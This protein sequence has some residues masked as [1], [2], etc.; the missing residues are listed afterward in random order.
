MF[1]KATVISALAGL[2]VAAPYHPT[3]VH[4]P[5]IFVANINHSGSPIQFSAV[6]AKGLEFNVNNG[7]KTYCPAGQVDCSHAGTATVFAYQPE[8]QTLAMDVTVPGGQRAF[9]RKDGSLGFTI[10]HSGAIPEG[11]MLGPFQFTPQQESGTVGRLLFE[12]RG[13]NACK[14]G[15][16]G[17][18]GRDVYKLYALSIASKEQLEKECTDVVF[19]TA[20]WTGAMAWQSEMKSF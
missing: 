5:N 20:T 14:T 9:V 10:A 12:E 13:F 18:S 7:T 3:P 4:N 17:S 6:N 11:A 16:K 19:N 8:S 1:T 15:Q 2:A